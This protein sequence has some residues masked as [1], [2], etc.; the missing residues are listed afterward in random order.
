MASS[1][2]DWQSS[3]SLTECNRY[4]L[5]NNIGCDVTFLVGEERTKIL[6]HKY[7][8]I[9]RSCVFFAMFN[10]P[11][12]ETSEE[13]TLPDIEPNV[14]RIYRILNRFHSGNMPAQ[15]CLYFANK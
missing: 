3:K 2:E 11:L 15:N 13:I 9:G 4:M 8:L 1:E 5:E 14:F 6:A 7:I 12:A 10:G